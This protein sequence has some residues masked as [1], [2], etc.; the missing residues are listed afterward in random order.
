MRAQTKLYISVK[1]R[2]KEKDRKPSETQEGSKKPVYCVKR[3]VQ[4]SS[5]KNVSVF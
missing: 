2:V 3:K 5:L 1:V 4:S